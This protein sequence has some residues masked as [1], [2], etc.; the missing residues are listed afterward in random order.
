LTINDSTKILAI[1]SIASI[2]AACGSGGDGGSTPAPPAVNRAPVVDAGTDASID[3]VAESLATNGTVSDDGLPMGSILTTVW[4][5]Q[6]GPGGATFADQ[7]AVDTTVTFAE[8]GTYIL[9]LSANDSELQSTDTLTVVIGAATTPVADAGGPYSAIQ[10]TSAQLDASGSTDPNDDITIYEWDLDGDGVF[11]DA[12]GINAA[13]VTAAP[14]VYTIGLRVTDGDGNSDTVTTTV[15]VTNAA[16]S[17]NSQSVS[18]NQDTSLG[19]VLQASD[20]GSDPL[21]FSITASPQ[22]G[23]LSGE[24]PNVTYAP[25]AGFS[26]TDSFTFTAS[27][28]DLDSSEA[29]VT[30][31]VVASSGLVAHWTKDEGSGT[32]VLDASGNGNVGMLVNNPSW[33]VGRID[34]ALDFDGLDDHVQVADRTNLDIASD[35][36]IAAWIFPRTLGTNDQG[37]IVD[38]A[39]HDGTGGYVFRLNSAN[40]IGFQQSGVVAGVDS[41]DNAISLNAWNHVTAVVESGTLVT[42]Y[43]DGAFV[44]SG[45]LSSPITANNKSLRIGIR[46]D[47]GQAFD[48]IIDDLRVYERA[49]PVS[50]INELYALGSDKFDIDDRIQTTLDLEVRDT[51]ATNGTLLGTQLLDALGTIIAGPVAADG[52]NWWRVN[53]DSGPDGW[54]IE[55]WLEQPASSG[56]YPVPDSSGGWRSLVTINATP[57]AAQKTGI[58][59]TAGIDWD[60]LESAWNF[61]ETVGPGSTVLVI[62]RG[63]IAGEWGSTAKYNVASV[64]KSLT[65]LAVAKLM[66]LSD[67][68]SFT[69]SIGLESLASEFL[70]QA[71]GDSDPL[72]NDI[73]IKHLLTMSP[74]IR[75]AD[76]DLLTMTERLTYPMDAPPESEWVYSSLPPNLLSMILQAVAGQSFGDFFNAEI[77]SAIGATQLNWETI[78]GGYT[79]GAAGALVGARDL[80]RIAYLTLR[81]GIWDSGAGPR[82][83]VSQSR[84]NTMTQWAPFLANTSFRES[85]GSPFPLPADSPNHYGYLWWTNRTQIAL[86]GQV[87]TDAYYM[88]GFR[89]NLAVVI[90]SEDLIVIRMANSGPATDTTFRSQ[91]M[92]LVMSSLVN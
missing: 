10:G 19:I 33:T 67:A 91:F 55:D 22:N 58:R 16:P 8:S 47:G 46:H 29:T 54:S 41:G 38:K 81:G 20:P 2:V 15:T 65:S 68:G 73:K 31:S 84:V 50:E 39:S 77:S 23:A 51:P 88:H 71:F 66:D 76:P 72:K 3:S 64:T 74:G 35:L 80:A 28:G 45:T 32:L 17:A 60:L 89:D 52:F 25:D 14:G 56:Y 83:I 62:R 12:S 5:V 27:D 43:V 4:S 63:W 30:I 21:S 6:S 70:P 42:L 26:G 69:R 90:P 49:I 11:D 57:S 13:Y 61:S 75:P 78:D 34:G 36:T 85:P 53:Y 48:G 1:I 40:R 44:G 37:R 24:A 86:G 7:S 79:K 92:S 87:P 9:Q 59:E 82:Q 18:T